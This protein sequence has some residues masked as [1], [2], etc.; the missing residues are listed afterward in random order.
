MKVEKK[1]I[2]KLNKCYAMAELVDGGEHKFLVA[3]EKADPCYLCSEDGEVLETVWKEPGG[4]MTMQQVPGVDGQFLS[5]QR[6]FSPNDSKNAS[7]AVVTHKGKDDWEIRTLCEAPFVHRFGILE[8]NGTRYLLVCCLKSGHEYK[9]DWRFPGACYASVLP[10]DLS[11]FNAEHQLTLTKIKDGMLRN[12]GYRAMTIDGHDAAIVG[13][14]E[15][16]FLFTPPVKPDADWEIRQLCGVPASDSILLDFDGDGKLELGTISP[17][18]GAALAI[19]HL[20]EF[21]NYVPAWK[22]PLPEA[23]TEFLH[24]TWS[25][26]L[27]GKEAWVVGWR[28]G[29]R[30]TIAI[31]YENGAYQTE[32]IDSNTGCANLMHF[33]NKDGKDVLVATNREIDE[34]AMYTITA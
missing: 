34:A 25:G 30:Q 20:D 4:I 13:C 22:L 2:T 24:S 7:I 8:R 27:A 32:V 29:T 26:T 12:H 14:E 33:V 19:Y 11:P 6:F 21:G 31:T 18:H 5:T 10:S 9:N 17:F 3:A 28:K 16:T 23:D 1:V 15:G